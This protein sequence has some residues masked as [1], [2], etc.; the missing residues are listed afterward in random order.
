MNV[1]LSPTI[2]SSGRGQVVAEIYPGGDRSPS[3]VIHDDELGGFRLGPNNTDIVQYGAEAIRY[4]LVNNGV[5]GEAVGVCFDATTA[6]IWLDRGN[7]VRKLSAIRDDQS[8]I[9]WGSDEVT[10]R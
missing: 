3:Y 9:A 4:R 10:I 6:D 2:T 8:V 1:E 7:A 5:H